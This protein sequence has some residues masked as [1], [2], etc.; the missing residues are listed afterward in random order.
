VTAMTR[1]TDGVVLLVDDEERNLDLLEDILD[2]AGY[3]RLVRVSDARQA[4]AAF[5]RARPDVVLLDLHMPHR[6]GF[7]VLAD[8][9]ARTPADAYLPVL[10]LTADAT[11][12]A[13][14]RALQGGAQDFLTKPF[15]NDE[16][17][18]R[19]RNLL[20]TRC[21]HEQQAR[22]RAA[23]ELLADAGRVLATT[24]DAATAADHVAHLLVRTL[25]HR[26]TVDLVDDAGDWTRVASAARPSTGDEETSGDAGRTASLSGDGALPLASDPG[27]AGDAERPVSP[28]PV[29]DGGFSLAGEGDA[30]AAVH[31]A[32]MRAGS[33]ETGRVTVVRDG[34]GF[35]A[36]EAALVGEIARRVAMALE[37]ARLVRDAQAAVQ[38]RERTLAVVAHELR[39]PLTAVRMD[40]E[41]LS[42]RLTE[43]AHAGEARRAARIEQ[44]AARMDRLI[45]DLM[46][47]SRLERGALSVSPRP[48]ALAPILAEAGET[49]APLAAAHGLRFEVR[50]DTAGARVHADPVRV[51]QVVSNLVGNA[52]KFTPA[53]GLVVLGATASGDGCEVRV[54]DSGDGLSAEELPHVFGAFWQARH[55]D[56]RGLGLGLAIARALVEAHG[57]RIWVES[58]P[59]RGTTFRFTLPSASPDDD[60]ARA[61]AGR[62]EPTRT[63]ARA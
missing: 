54:E 49:L 20:E 63:P 5:E 27:D 36:D 17:L 38:A 57:G 4:V 19:V 9:R 12:E 28:T 29:T 43:P 41:M 2:R 32:S 33:R 24:L 46:E 21:L 47:V 30:G 7:E 48:A 35:T 39:N 16:V 11:F 50:D 61:G 51:V 56:R 1:P 59:G 18:L 10:V 3:G 6:T 44:A 13:K 52:I 23:A 8:L 26:C 58:A 45:E 25:A 42:T 14:R 15:Q 55:A 31:V 34:D 53:G 40:A 60:T 62:A 22:A 37:N